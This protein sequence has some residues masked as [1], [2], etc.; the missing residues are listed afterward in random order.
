MF[1]GTVIIFIIKINFIDNAHWI[2][3][4]CAYI[5]LSVT[6]AAKM[7]PNRFFRKSPFCYYIEKRTYQNHSELFPLPIL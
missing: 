4:V 1:T 6:C 3:T 7:C 5:L 2:L